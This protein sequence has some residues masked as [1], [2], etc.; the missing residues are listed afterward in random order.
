MTKQETKQQ[1]KQNLA[2]WRQWHRILGSIVG[3][4]LFIW[5]ITGLYFN[6]VPS[7]Y[8][9]GTSYLTRVKAPL[10][11]VVDIKAFDSAK[12]LTRFPNTEK[13]ELVMLANQAFVLLTHQQMRYSHQCQQQSLIKLGSSDKTD[14][15][16]ELAKAIAMQSYSGAGEIIAATK[17]LAAHWEWGK[18]CNDLWRVDFNDELNTRVY[19]Q[20]NSGLVIGHK[21]RYTSIS[22]WVFRLHFMDYLNRG[23]FN[24]IFSWSFAAL[25]LLLVVTG[26][27]AIYQNWRL[28]RYKK[29]HSNT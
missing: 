7:E 9:K 16:I 19:I 5:L 13:I 24:N 8:L 18:E 29:H 12:L 4:Q 6:L 2:R 25:A 1:V 11:D 27:H 20:A 15:N 17:M 10:T 23:S 28:G 14:V 21:N 26:I 22:D 3:L